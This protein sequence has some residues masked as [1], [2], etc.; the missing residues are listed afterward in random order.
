MLSEISYRKMNTVY[1]YLHVE[2][3]KKNE[4]MNTTRKRFTGIE[5]K[6]VVTSGERG[7]GRGKIREED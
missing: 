7:E 3:K 6:V 2:S 1:F 4:W 5:N